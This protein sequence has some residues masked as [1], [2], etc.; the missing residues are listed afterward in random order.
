MKRGGWHLS[1]AS[2]M[3]GMISSFTTEKPSGKSLILVTILPEGGRRAWERKE[4]SRTV[5]A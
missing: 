1:A 2:K 4:V 5:M 3:R